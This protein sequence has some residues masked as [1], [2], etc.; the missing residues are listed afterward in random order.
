MIEAGAS[1]TCKPHQRIAERINLKPNHH[2]L[3]IVVP[4]RSLLDLRAVLAWK[5]RFAV[6]EPQ[7]EPSLTSSMQAVDLE[8]KHHPIIV[9]VSGLREG[10]HLYTDIGDFD[11]KEDIMAPLFPPIATHLAD[12]P[13]I[14]LFVVNS[15]SSERHAP[16][17]FVEAI[18]EN[19][20]IGYIGCDYLRRAG[21]IVEKSPS[22]SV[23]N[24]FTSISHKLQSLHDVLR[25]ADIVEDELAHPSMSVQEIFTSISDKLPPHA[26][27]TVIDR[28][29]EPV[30]LHPCGSELM[31]TH[32]RTQGI[33]DYMS[34]MY[35]HTSRHASLPTLESTE[36]SGFLSRVRQ[37][38]IAA[39]EPDTE[40]HLLEQPIKKLE[41]ELSPKQSKGVPKQA[42]SSDEL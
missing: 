28:L 6:Y 20:I 10:N 3:A 24:I 4:F 1:I 27:M 42:E 11:I 13:K 34:I 40:S 16:L 2:G 32:S 5:L 35:S 17:H 25:V 36:E 9:V 31:E 12:K 33:V 23:Q 38:S 37:L 26:T 19:Y 29:K 30:Y 7:D 39:K 15:N 8:L 18:W 22:M 14:F 41:T 21:D